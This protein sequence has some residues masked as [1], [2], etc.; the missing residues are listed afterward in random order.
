MRCFVQDLSLNVHSYLNLFLNGSI[1]SLDNGSVTTSYWVKNMHLS[2]V[3][4]V[5]ITHECEWYRMTC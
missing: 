5:K 2:L 3:A 1:S 4:Y